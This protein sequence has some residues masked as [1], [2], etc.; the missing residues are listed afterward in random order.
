MRRDLPGSQSLRSERDHQLI[1]TGESALALLDDLRLERPITIARDVDLDLANLGQ[2][3]LRAASVARVALVATLG[4]VLRI[5]EVVLHLHLERGLE[6]RLRQIAQK[7]ARTNELRTLRPRA[8]DQL[9]RE[10]LIH[11]RLSGRRHLLRHYEPPS[12]NHAAGKSGPRSYTVSRTVPGAT[13]GNR[14]QVRRASMVAGVSTP[15]GKRGEAVSGLAPRLT[16]RT[17]PYDIH[18]TRRDRVEWISSSVRSDSCVQLR[19]QGLGALRAAA[20]SNQPEPAAVRAARYDVR[21]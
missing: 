17:E 4:R 19:A 6:H 5:A 14:W 20:A 18:L 13:S 1:D 8:C 11:R 16:L 9:L 7:T 10:L 2:D 15:E 3:R 12:A 21:R